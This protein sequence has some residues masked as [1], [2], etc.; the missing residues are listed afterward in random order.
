MSNYTTL[1]AARDG[2]R[3]QKIIGGRQETEL[4]R[5]R[6]QIFREQ[7]GWVPVSVDGLDRDDYDVFSENFAVL[8][9]HKVVGS[10]RLTAGEYPFMLE[11]EFSALLP[12]DYVLQKGVQGAEITRFAAGVDA[13]GRRIESASRLLWFGL[14]QWAMHKNVRWMYFVVE[15]PFFRHIVRLGFP[16]FSLGKARPLDGGVLSQAGYFDWQQRS[17]QLIRWLHSGLSAPVVAQAQ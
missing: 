1:V 4:L 14:Y 12:K 5:F 17:P 9:Q 10:L 3:L 2:Y 15:P 8:Q 13:A 16:V 7:L 11:K 6:H